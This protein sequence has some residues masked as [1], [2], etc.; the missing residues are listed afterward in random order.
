MAEVFFFFFSSLNFWKQ[1]DAEKTRVF[2]F[3][4]PPRASQKGGF[5]KRGFGG[6]SP[7]PKEGTRVHSDVPRYQRKERR[8]IRMFPGTASRNDWNICQNRPFTKPPFCFLSILEEEERK[9]ENKI[10][11][12]KK[13]ITESRKKIKS[14][15]YKNKDWRV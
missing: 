9:T 4:S 11:N 12:K 1:G 14:K 13:K 5:Q 3:K 2:L 7:V 10:K 6:C 15:K 8:Y